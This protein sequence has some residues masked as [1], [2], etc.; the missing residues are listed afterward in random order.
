M[1]IV[2]FLIKG[3]KDKSYSEYV[4]ERKIWKNHA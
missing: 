1:R 4:F 2:P 3:D